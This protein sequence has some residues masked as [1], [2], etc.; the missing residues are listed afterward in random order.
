MGYRAQK[1]SASASS[2]TIAKTSG[3]QAIRSFS[4]CVWLLKEKK[5]EFP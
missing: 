5:S 4:R 2:K 3:P 1:K